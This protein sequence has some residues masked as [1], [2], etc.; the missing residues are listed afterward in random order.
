VRSTSIAGRIRFMA[1]TGADAGHNAFVGPIARRS[2]VGLFLLFR[3][4]GPTSRPMSPL[5]S[6]DAIRKALKSRR[7]FTPRLTVNGTRRIL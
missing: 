3:S 2:D 6:G 5:R 7:G 4:E 1:R